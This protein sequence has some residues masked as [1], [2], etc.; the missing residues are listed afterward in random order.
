VFDLAAEVVHPLEDY[1]YGNDPIVRSGLEVFD[2]K[3]SSL[4]DQIE[5]A[6]L[7]LIQRNVGADS[8]NL[9]GGLL[10][11]LLLLL[12]LVVRTSHIRTLLILV[13]LIQLVLLLQLE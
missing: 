2:T 12:L 3:S 5:A 10:L 9:E 8:T 4:S 7:L 11:F 1:E 13:Q 6:D